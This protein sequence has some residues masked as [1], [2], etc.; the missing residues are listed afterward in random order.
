MYLFDIIEAN[1]FSKILVKLHMI[2]LL[3]KFIRLLLRKGGIKKLEN[4][5]Y[6]TQQ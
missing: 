1:S 6:K 5:L 3:I 2:W 4:F